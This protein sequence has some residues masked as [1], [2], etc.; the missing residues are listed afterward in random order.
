MKKSIEIPLKDGSKMI[1]D[2]NVDHD[3]SEE[4]S[5]YNEPLLL[6]LS[7]L[8]S[9]DA[10]NT[11]EIL[12]AH[13][14][15][16]SQL[17]LEDIQLH[18]FTQHRVFGSRFLIKM[19]KSDDTVATIIHGMYF[20]LL[21]ISTRDA[22]SNIIDYSSIIYDLEISKSSKN[23]NSYRTLV[24]EGLCLILW[25]TEPGQEMDVEAVVKFML[26]LELIEREL[27]ISEGHDSKWLKHFIVHFPGADV[28]RIIHNRYTRGIDYSLPFGG[29][30]GTEPQNFVLFG[31]SM[32]YD[33]KY[34]KP[35]SYEDSIEPQNKQRQ[36]L[37]LPIN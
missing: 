16:L 6:N 36:R 4:D 7:S 15:N 18:Q 27:A 25:Q 12:N 30:S 3:L 14:G 29:F 35:P 5:A 17:R 26:S 31:N 8:A 22:L 13:Y 28:R 33:L 24:S 2:S 1:A 21:H 23:I 19:L 34:L 9:G 32:S 37:K 20:K 10:R 11:D